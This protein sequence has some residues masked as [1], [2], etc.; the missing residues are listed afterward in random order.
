MYSPLS[1]IVANNFKKTFEDVR[2]VGDT[3]NIWPHGK[4][5]Q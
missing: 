2:Y 4:D 5:T 1:P 3:F